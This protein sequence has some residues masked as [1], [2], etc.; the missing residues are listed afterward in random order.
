MRLQAYL[1]ARGE[2]PE[3]LADRAG[4]SGMGLRRIVK[5]G[6]PNMKLAWKVVEATKSEP[7]SDG[8]S[9]TLSDLVMEA[10]EADLT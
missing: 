5:G 1:E 6:W 10:L 9:V 8:R 3:A 2:S 7:T 4:V